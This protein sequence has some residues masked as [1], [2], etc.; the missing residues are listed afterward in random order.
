M[1][2]LHIKRLANK[3]K[4]SLPKLVGSYRN[5]ESI[6]YIARKVHYPSYLLARCIVEEITLLEKKA[7]TEAM[8]DPLVKLDS[9]NII[10][11]K[12]HDSVSEKSSLP[13]TITSRLA[14]EVKDAIDSDPMHGPIHDKTRHI[15]GVEFEVVLECKLKSLGKSFDKLQIK[16]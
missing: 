4:N 11:P 6:R 5:G 16:C 15:V 2:L 10:K 1:Y 8:K 9:M 14:R 13:S 3:V 12:Y 7:L